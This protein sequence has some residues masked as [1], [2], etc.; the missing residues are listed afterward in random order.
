MKLVILT[1]LLVGSV[2]A[3]PQLLPQQQ[4]QQQPGV[5]DG[6]ANLPQQAIGALFFIPNLFNTLATGVLQTSQ[7]ATGSYVNNFA[8]PLNNVQSLLGRPP[9]AVVTSQQISQQAPQQIPQ[10]VLPIFP[11][12]LI[13]IAQAPQRANNGLLG[14]LPVNWFGQNQNQIPN[15]QPEAVN[16]VIL[17]PRQKPPPPQFAEPSAPVVP[18]NENAPVPVRVGAPSSNCTESGTLFD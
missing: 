13:N 11:Q 10:Q 2:I 5:F 8:G 7:Q 9:Q 17:P 16:V 6:L 12:G 18:L 4:Q 1:V 15:A 14:L 3:A